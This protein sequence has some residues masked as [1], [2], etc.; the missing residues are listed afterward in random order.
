MSCVDF[1]AVGQPSLAKSNAANGS[2]KWVV[3]VTH[4]SL[5]D[6]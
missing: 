1:S 5:S 3:M 4:T 2:G 6:L